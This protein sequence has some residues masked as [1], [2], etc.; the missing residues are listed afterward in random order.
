M[1]PTRLVGFQLDVKVIGPVPG[2]EI[3]PKPNPH[4]NLPKPNPLPTPHPVIFQPTKSPTPQPIKPSIPQ[5]ITPT[6]TF[7]SLPV[8]QNHPPSQSASRRFDSRNDVT[9]EIKTKGLNLNPINLKEV[10]LLSFEES[11]FPIQSLVKELDDFIF[12]VTARA[13]NEDQF[14]NGITRDIACALNLYKD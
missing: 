2:I 11:L 12:V 3:Y 6:F 14:E 13:E 8:P 9:E 10:P 1:Q 5:H 4:N 7:E